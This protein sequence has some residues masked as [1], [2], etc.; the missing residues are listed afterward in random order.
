MTSDVKQAIEI[1]VKAIKDDKD[2]YYAWQSNI[3]MAIKD[4]W[5]KEMPVRGIR[6]ASKDIH[7]LANESAKR[8]LDL[9]IYNNK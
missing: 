6:G 3:A 8:F 9:L 5:D 4:E 1:L 2:L 7:V